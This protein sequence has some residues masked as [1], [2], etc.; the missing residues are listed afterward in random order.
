MHLARAEH[1]LL[2]A[3]HHIVSDDWSRAVVAREVG[4][5]YAALGE[6]R[7]SP[8][9]ELGFQYADFALW[10]RGWLRG[11]AL[12]AEL[13]FW[14]ERFAGAPEGIELPLDRPRPPVRSLRGDRRRHALPPALKAGLAALAA[15]H[16]ATLY[17]ALLAAFAA[18]LQRYSGQRDLLVGSP[19]A[20]RTEEELE[21]L[22]GFFVNTL[23]LRIDVGGGPSFRELL[24]RVR[25]VCLQSYAH[26]HLPF[27]HL[28]EALEP[29]R[30]LSHNPLFQVLFVFQAAGMPEVEPGE[31]SMRPL[32]AGQETSMFDLVLSLAE[33]GER[34]AVLADFSRDLFDGATVARAL[35]HLETLLA[36]AVEA[37]ERP[38][39]A[40]ALLTTPE[41][42]Q[43]LRE[44]NRVAEEPRGPRLLFELVSEHVRSRPEAIAVVDGGVHVSYGELGELAA[45][46]AHRLAAAGTVP[47]DLVGVLARRGLEQVSSVA[48]ILASGAG[49]LPLDPDHPPERLR[50]M[51]ADAGAR[52]VVVARGLA[53]H[54]GAGGPRALRPETPRHGG[55]PAVDGSRLR[56]P[57]PDHPAYAIYTSGSTGRPKG[58]VVPHRGVVDTLL[59]RRR[60]FRVGPADRILATVPPTFDPS[61]WQTFGALGNGACLVMAPPDAGRDAAGLGRLLLREAITITDFPPSLLEALLGEEGEGLE[62]PALRHLFCGG[63]ALP[64]RL[65]DRFA[66]RS[67]ARL[68]NVYGPTETCIDAASWTCLPGPEAQPVPIGRPIGGK[69]LH[70]LDRELR[71]LPAGVAGG[72]WIGGTGLSRGYAGRPAETAAS[73]RPDPFAGSPGRR[74]YGSGDVARHRFG[75]E[76]EFL[77]RADDQVKIR[78]FRVELGEVEAALVEHPEVAEA[79]VV[80][81]EGPA[82]AAGAAGDAALVGYVGAPRPVAPEELASFLRGRLPGYMVPASLVVLEALPRTSNGKVDRSALPPAVWA[83]RA[84]HVAPRGGVEEVL[85]A[86]WKDLLG[87][88]RIGRED[89]FFELGGH[90]LLVTR[91]ASRVRSTLGV[92][93]PVRRVFEGPRLREMATE[94]RRLR[95]LGGAAGGS[96]RRRPSWRCRGT[97]RRRSPS[98]RSGSG[99]STSSPPRVLPTTS[100]APTGS[101]RRRRWPSRRPSPRSS[102]ATRSC[103]R[104]SRRSTASRCR[105]SRRRGRRGCPWSTCGG[106]PARSANERRRGSAAS[107]RAAPSTSR[108][109]RRYAWR[110]SSTAARRSS[111]R[112]S[113]IS[114]A[115]A[116][117]RRSS[118]ASSRPSS[119]PFAPGGPRHCRSCRCSMPTSPS[120]SG[121]GSRAPC[122]RRRSATGGGGSRA[123]RPLSGCRPTGR[124]PRWRHPRV[125]GSRCR[126][127]RGWASVSSASPASARRPP[128]WCS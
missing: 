43:L 116:G 74:L 126:W 124:G 110:S 24:A 101:P 117:R 10:Q 4:A 46:L 109:R 97:S 37:P 18:L 107:S 90:S 16:G 61:V 35:R 50:G 103:A 72:L 63:E 127:R 56:K 99:S 92:E 96:P 118:A 1:A 91:L 19:V 80:L 42:H 95:G 112:P 71:L 59:W 75:G 53:Y 88:D 3:M 9:P 60:R 51:L 55:A 128:S 44:W 76:L 68:H 48:G 8:L 52:A 114:P 98:A 27:E 2:A 105:R 57:H 93:L 122:S 89:S 108:P 54:P 13:D 62:A 6:G 17:M 69:R 15:R 26:R 102:G 28:V 85:A 81:A 22:V 33:E 7:P 125:R 115:T 49:F 65:V 36:G 23:V 47:G 120:G 30:D 121:G 32:S 29:Q 25:R 11:K 111:A 34:L 86:I 20:N 12:E 64:R 70:V 123:F 21:G 38:L 100:R 82:A 84:E 58:V 66:R 40:L 45:V 5:L 41:V 67:A 39:S 113:T 119:A 79:T 77:G 83:S 104:R 14:R 106:S 94:V 87:R 31:L 78:G 73:F